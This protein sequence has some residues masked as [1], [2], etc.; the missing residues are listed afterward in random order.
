MKTLITI[1]VV[2]L[3]LTA[4]AKIDTVYAE[5]ND[6][7]YAPITNAECE[8]EIKLPD[9]TFVDWFIV[10]TDLNTLKFCEVT[11]RDSANLCPEH[12]DSFYLII[13]DTVIIDT[14]VIDT[15]TS[16]KYQNAPRLTFKNPSNELYLS[17]QVDVTIWNLN[18]PMVYK[19]NTNHVKLN[20]GFYIAIMEKKTYKIVIQ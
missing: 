13:T 9:S 4:N 20:T 1:I 5:I 17:K 16:I 2:F 15:V 3:G 6:T 14:I 18:G 19:G 8:K 12:I 7:I 11:K 10:T